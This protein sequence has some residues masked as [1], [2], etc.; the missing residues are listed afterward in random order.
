MSEIN[1]AIV[2]SRVGSDPYVG[3][4]RS[5]FS[6]ANDQS[7]KK[8]GN[9]VE[10]TVWINCVGFRSTAEFINK[11]IKKGDKVLVEGKI[12][13]RDYEKDG[14]TRKVTEIVIDN[15]SKQNW[16]KSNNQAPAQDQGNSNEPDDFPF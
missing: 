13:V 8:D 6:L 12:S 14:V 5:T 4:G 7:Y 11:F 1:K 10:K 9:K 16:E 15:V 2:E 3:E